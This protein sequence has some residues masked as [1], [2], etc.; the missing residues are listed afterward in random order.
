MQSNK[1]P[2]KKRSTTEAYKNSLGNKFTLPQQNDK[3]SNKLNK[4]IYNYSPM[5]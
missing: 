3:R 1:V 4:V 2:N 5:M